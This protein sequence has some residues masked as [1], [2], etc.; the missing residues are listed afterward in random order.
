MTTIET[1]TVQDQKCIE[2][3]ATLLSNLKT[4]SRKG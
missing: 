4:P 1:V 3:F 2:T